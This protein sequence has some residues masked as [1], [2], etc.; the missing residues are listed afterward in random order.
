MLGDG[1]RE[2]QDHCSNCLT[3]Q[4]SFMDFNSVSKLASEL[5][6]ESDAIVNEAFKMRKRTKMTKGT[7]HTKKSRPVDAAAKAHQACVLGLSSLVLMH[8]YEMAPYTP[9]AVV[10]IA[11]H[12]DAGGFV[13]EIVTKALAEFKRTRTGKDWE[14]QR[15][16]FTTAQLDSYHDASAVPSYF[17]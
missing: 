2:V 11:S 15:Q 7:N 17:S 3:L 6:S 1:H 14:E 4:L 16:C 8:P 12:A 13:K 10:A 9:E 5:I